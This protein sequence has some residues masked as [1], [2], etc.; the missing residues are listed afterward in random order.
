[1]MLHGQHTI[2]GPK[3]PALSSEC[4]QSLERERECHTGAYFI[5]HTPSQTRLR[6][7]LGRNMHNEFRC[8][9]RREALN[10]FN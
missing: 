9:G 6:H 5:C 1:M 7:S 8:P 4:V 10:N 2:T 3:H